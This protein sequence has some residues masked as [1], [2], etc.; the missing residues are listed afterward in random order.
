MSKYAPDDQELVDALVMIILREISQGRDQRVLIIGKATDGSREVR[1][2][3][4]A[5]ELRNGTHLSRLREIQSSQEY[6]PEAIAMIGFGHR[7]FVMVQLVQVKNK[8]FRLRVPD[9]STKLRWVSVSDRMEQ[10]WDK[11]FQGFKF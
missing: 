4:S 9:P 1:D 11:L 3:I 8:L 10:R 7:N 5:D 2:V 6:E